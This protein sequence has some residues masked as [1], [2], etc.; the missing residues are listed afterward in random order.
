[1]DSEAKKLIDIHDQ[2]LK[3]AQSWLDKAPFNRTEK[4]VI[5]QNSPLN[6]ETFLE[7]DPRLKDT[8]V[9]DSFSNTILLKKANQALGEETTGDWSDATDSMLRIY[10]ERHYHIVFNKGN[11]TDGVI[12]TAH[13]HSFDPV[14]ERIESEKWDGVS[15]V[16]T[17]FV[18]CLG[19][20]NNDYVRDVTE[21]WFRGAIARV[22]QPGIKFEIVPILTGIQGLGKSTVIRNLYPDKFNDNLKHLGKD[23]DDFQQLIGSWLIEIGELS[24]MAK[25]DIEQIKSF[26]S[27][28]N[29]RYRPSYGRHAVNHPRRCV[30][31]GTTNHRD[32]LKDET[33]ERRFYPIECG[34]QSAKYD[35][36]QPDEHYLL[37]VLAEAKVLYEQHRPLILQPVTLKVAKSY[38]KEATAVNPV[39]DAIE[40]YLDMDVPR[41]WHELS[42][43]SKQYFVEH[44]PQI[45]HTAKGLAQNPYQEPYQPITVTTARE[46]LAVVFHKT[47]DKYL[48]G[49][50]NSEA[51]K[52][53]LFMDNQ[54]DWKPA[55]IR[56]NGKRVHAY[57][58]NV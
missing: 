19:T 2:Q 3:H 49:R 14:K 15:R 43:E 42:I 7:H 28:Q 46:I 22:Y 25:T 41:N 56:Q 20:E 40:D 26:I 9:Y 32:Y 8:V 1:M 21:T 29:D 10:L 13:R 58:N 50:T 55:K 45:K 18:D 35:P 27:G 11:I 17:Y 53:K 44:Y 57:I 16:A 36:W 30:F 6:V 51:K 33:G 31:V 47:A 37:Q 34:I 48:T 5:K 54:D 24:A 4:G 39:D 38:Q 52:I 23:K 12:S